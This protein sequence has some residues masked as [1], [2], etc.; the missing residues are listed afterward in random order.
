[1]KTR[2]KQIEAIFKA[3]KKRRRELGLLSVEEK[4]AILI[5]MQKMSSSILRSR[6][7]EKNPWG[8]MTSKLFQIKDQSTPQLHHIVF[9]DGYV[10]GSSSSKT[11]A[12][13]K[14]F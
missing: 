7:I 5:E 2:K 3:K 14:D 11:N 10:L 13:W 4:F 8:E 1:M 12:I 9:S 6:G